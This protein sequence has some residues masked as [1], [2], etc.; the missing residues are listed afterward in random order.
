[1]NLFAISF[2]LFQGCSQLT[3]MNTPS[4]STATFGNSAGELEDVLVKAGVFPIN[5]DTLLY[6][7]NGFSS[8]SME[9]GF[10]YDM[11]LWSRKKDNNTCRLPLCTTVARSIVWENVRHIFALNM[12]TIYKTNGLTRS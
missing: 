7:V 2:S 3:I 11:K 12:P 4:F 8:G 1:M 10:Y 6:G 5:L 9:S